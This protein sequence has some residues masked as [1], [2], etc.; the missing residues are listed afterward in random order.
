MDMSELAKAMNPEQA[1][2]MSLFRALGPSY[3]NMLETR[4]EAADSKKTKVQP[5]ALVFRKR[6]KQS[7]Q[8]SDNSESDHGPQSSSP[9]SK[10][11]HDYS[12]ETI[13]GFSD[14]EMEV[15]EEDINYNTEAANDQSSLL[16]TAIY[17]DE[18]LWPGVGSYT[19][20]ELLFESGRSLCDDQ[21]GIHFSFNPQ[22]SL[23][24]EHSTRFSKIHRQLLASFLHI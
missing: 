19:V 8:P 12:F 5:R 2:A 15:A 11:P 22:A 4:Q 13:L 18:L 6:S 3:L 10:Q 9:K 21:N 20:C 14:D 7:R 1:L 24:F 23:H 17:N 16:C